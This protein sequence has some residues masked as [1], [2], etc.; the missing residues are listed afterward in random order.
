L[1]DWSPG[2]LQPLSRPLS[3]PADMD[4][5]WCEFLATGNTEAVLRVIDVLSRPDR[6]RTHLE[7][8]LRSGPV[9]GLGYLDRIHR[10]WIIRRLRKGA[11]IS[12][13]LERGEVVTAQDLDC[14][15]TM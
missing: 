13:D 1:Q 5:H 11:S 10:K 3:S 7:D 9:N 15:C 6:I 8:W 2:A 14:Y 12:C 4:L